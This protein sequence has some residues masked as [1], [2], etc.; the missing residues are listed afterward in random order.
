MNPPLNIL[1]AYPYVTKGVIS[2]LLDLPEGSRFLLDCGAF[3]A[4]AGGKPIALDDYC[5]FIETLPIT[6]WRYFALDVIGDPEATRVNYEIMLDRGFKPVPILTPG[7]SLDVMDSY[8]E[9]SEVVGI[10]GLTGMGPKKHGYVRALVRHAAGRKLHLLGYTSPKW[11]MHHRP[12]MCDAS[13]WE[14]GARYGALNLYMGGGRFA[15]ITKAD[16]AQRPATEILDR[17]QAL[18]VDPYAMAKN[19]AWSGGNSCSRN[20][21]AASWVAYSMDLERTLGTKLFL[22][23]AQ[24]YSLRIIAKTY[25]RLAL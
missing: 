22:A 6:P 4:W 15:A 13:T 25:R 10:G 3:T 1:V 8:W 9:T 18:G 19:A 24:E 23:N 12:Y 5:R 7:E 17:I 16:F 14:S 21:G 20:L 2:A 11:L